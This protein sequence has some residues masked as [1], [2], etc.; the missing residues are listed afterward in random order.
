VYDALVDG[1]SLVSNYR[2]QFAALLYSTSYEQLVGSLR[3]KIANNN[4]NTK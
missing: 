4:V 3:E 2:A 1:I